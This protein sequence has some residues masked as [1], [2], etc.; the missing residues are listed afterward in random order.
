LSRTQTALLNTAAKAD[1]HS[2][3]FYRDKVWARDKKFNSIFG[4]LGD[5]IP[6]RCNLDFPSDWL[7][8]GH[9]SPDLTPPFSLRSIYRNSRLGAT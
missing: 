3:A 6:A 9:S 1:L 7:G 5:T 4:L 2:R 8:S